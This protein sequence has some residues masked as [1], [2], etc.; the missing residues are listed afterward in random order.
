MRTSTPPTVSGSGRYR[1]AILI[2]AAGLLGLAGSAQA[3]L[4][5]ITNPSFELPNASGSP[6]GV[7]TVISSWDKLPQPGYFDPGT[8]FLTWDSVAG[9]FPNA[10]APDPRHLTNAD[11]SQVAYIFA[12]T[13]AG[14]SQTLS[15]SFAAGMSYT[16][17][18]GLRGGGS[19]AAGTPFLAGLQYF[20]GTDWT[21]V[22][23]TVVTATAGYNT[24]T[25]LQPVTVST[26][27]IAAGSPAVGKPIRVILEGTDFSASSGLAY[28]EADNLQ[29]NAVPEP[30]SYALVA[31]LALLGGALWRR[32]R[33][34]R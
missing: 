26:G 14:I 18:L 33:S 13:G 27:T 6:T 3:Q 1:T 17:T 32:S 24:V 8:F 11:G 19:L 16:L 15:T 2:A 9:I 34:S 30:E 21:N 31:G 28:W 10:P 29:L 12:F 25:A 23:A 4:V 20:D 22:G 7:S 5:G